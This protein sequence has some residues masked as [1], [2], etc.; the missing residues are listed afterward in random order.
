MKTYKYKIYHN[1]RNKRLHDTINV[2]GIIWNHC[3]ALHKRYYKLFGKKIGKYQLQKHIARLRKREQH[4]H[5]Q[6]VGSQVVQDI[7]ERIDKAYTL[8]FSNLKNGKKA[9][10]PKFKKVKKYKSMTFKQ[11]GYKFND[12]NS[13]VIQGRRYRYSKSR[14][15][16]G[17]I[18][19]VTV[20]RTVS[21]MYLYVVTD[22]VEI[23][24]SSRTL[25]GKSVGIDFGLKQFLTC[26]DN[27][28]I[29]SPQ[30]FK[31][32]LDKTR[33]FSKA[34]SS[35]KKGSNNF[36]KA[37]EAKARHLESI[38]NRK[39]DWFFKLSKSL[40]EDYD[41]IFIEDLSMQGMK[42]RWGRKVS[43]LSWAMF[44]SILEYQATKNGC[45]VKKIDKWYPSSKTCSQCGKVKEKL[46]L[47]ERVYKCSRCGFELDRDLNASRNIFI[48]GA[49][50]IGL[51]DVRPWGTKAIAV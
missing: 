29:E 1:R 9:S 32:G 42:A 35:K 4:E 17:N 31:Q 24:G 39:T 27:M 47:G 43:D 51:G 18:K 10:P 41:Y 23:G 26:S 12:D 13:L 16:E 34:V 19:T 48:E 25:S 6:L 21:G 20:K 2:S 28:T 14:E 37:V 36:K 40:T 5:W 15:I 22:H 8:F 30:F 7:I 11:A 45:V 49:S 3:I 46:G 38:V 44:V 50:S 33:R